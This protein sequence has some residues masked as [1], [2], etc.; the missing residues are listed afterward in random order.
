[1]Q[2]KDI[3]YKNRS[4]RK[5]Y[6]NEPIDKKVLIDLVD[7]GRMSASGGNTQ[8]L[9]YFIS[10]EP[11]TNEKIF[12]NISW[13]RYIK[14]AAPHK[15]D[16]PSGYIIILGDKSISSN[17][18]CDHGIAAQSILIGA[19]EKGLGGC[20]IATI[21]HEKLKNEIKL[22]EN[23]EILLVIALGTPKEMIVIEDLTPTGEVKYWRDEKGVHHVPKRKL[24]D[25]IINYK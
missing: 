2:I 16:R 6:E 25:I 17:F 1:M 22:K 15:G 5:F 4:Y 7:L 24:S 9:K 20:M 14:D 10:C 12:N 19:V 11:E 18:G 3:I 13:A 21:Q 23:L 8:P